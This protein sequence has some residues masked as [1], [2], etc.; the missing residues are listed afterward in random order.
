MKN[1]LKKKCIIFNGFGGLNFRHLVSFDC[2]DHKCDSYMRSTLKNIPFIR[3]VM[4]LE[5]RKK[6]QLLK[7]CFFFFIRL[8]KSMSFHTMHLF[9]S[10]GKIT[11]K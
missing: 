4:Q 3:C 6:C 7:D 8:L 10:I 9:A 11:S 1:I 2:E 5:I